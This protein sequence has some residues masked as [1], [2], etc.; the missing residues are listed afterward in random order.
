[1]K[2]DVK[3]F[4]AKLASGD[5]LALVDVREPDEF[6]DWSIP[7]TINIPLGDVEARMA[8]IPPGELIIIC[9]KGGRAA[10]AAELLAG[11]GLTPAVLEDGMAAWARAFDSASQN[12]RS[13][14]VV[15]LRRRGKGCLSY[16][17][18]SDDECVVIDP[19]MDG[20]RVLDLA[21]QHNWRIV[22][23]VDTHLHADHVSGASLLASLTG[24][25][26]L[27]NRADGG[28]RGTASLE[29]G[30]EIR[31]GSSMLRVLFTPGHTRGSTTYVLDNEA[32]FT[33]DV[34][35]IESV[36]RPDLADQ[37]EAFAH[38]L[39]ASLQKLMAFGDD[40]VVL[41]AHYGPSVAAPF[42]DMIETTIG[43][44]R[45]T[46]PALAQEEAPFVAWATEAAT[47]RPPSYQQIVA[48]NLSESEPSAQE[49][50][51]LEI[52][53]NRCAVATPH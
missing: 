6:A 31:F 4:V 19:P 41:P 42:G 49:A 39:Y 29:D 26:H 25:D 12:F 33:G 23:V 3:D 34:L 44:L 11:H 35:M 46:Q 40:T 36:G 38:E 20:E 13:A 52:G 5:V 28:A 51:E 48:L 32:L 37:A 7:G 45:A 18:G 21:K 24:A 9:A 17:V 47:L 10:Q 27:V 22:A 2:V 8:E 43:H 30:Q 53:P 16:L 14:Q 50:A 1:M 15:Q